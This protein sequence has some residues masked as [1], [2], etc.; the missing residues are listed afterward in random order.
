MG[1][2][3]K[4]GKKVQL[5]TLFKLGLSDREIHRKTGIHRTTISN[6]RK[7][8]TSETVPEVPTDPIG[9]PPSKNK[10]IVSHAKEIKQKYLQGLTAQRIYQDCVDGYC[11]E[12]GYDSIKRYIKKLKIKTP[13]HYDRL[14]H[15]AGHE[16]Q[17]D[18][19]VGPQVLK[20]GKYKKC[21]LFKMTLSFS[22]HSY[23]ELVWKQDI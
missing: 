18:F 16:G 1:N 13:K 15:P 10:F 20:D 21:W 11:Y 7:I 4:M 8:F 6:Y 22:G 3:L 9:I 14:L 23:E 2:E 5:V 17:V 19:G 12:G